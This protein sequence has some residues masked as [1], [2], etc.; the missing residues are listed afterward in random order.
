MLETSGGA[1]GQRLSD[2]IR[3]NPETEQAFRIGLDEPLAG[4]SPTPVVDEA[5]H[6][7]QVHL[8]EVHPR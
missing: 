5:E 7:Q 4:D 8:D 6:V 2:Q 1:E 3:R